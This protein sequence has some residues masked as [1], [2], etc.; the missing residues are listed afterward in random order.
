MKGSKGK[1][2]KT[3]KINDAKRAAANKAKQKSTGQK[4]TVKHMGGRHGINKR[5]IRCM[6]G[7]YTSIIKKTTRFRE[8]RM[9]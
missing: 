9:I 6:Q 8:C 3:F 2:R 7:Y 1:T 4:V 5:F